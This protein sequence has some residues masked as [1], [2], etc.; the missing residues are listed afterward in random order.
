MKAKETK[1]QKRERILHRLRELSS[2]PIDTESGHGEAD[3]LLLELI[4][5]QEIADAYNTINK[6]YS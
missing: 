1:A 2:D 4:D 3:D 5:D 6:W